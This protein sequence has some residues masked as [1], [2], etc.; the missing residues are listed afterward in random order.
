MNINIKVEEMI[1]LEHLENLRKGSYDWVSKEEYRIECEIAMP[2]LLAELKT[3]RDE[4][5]RFRNGYDN[6]LAAFRKA[7]ALPLECLS[8]EDLE[9]WT[10]TISGILLAL[11]PYMETGRPL[12]IME[13]LKEKIKDDHD[14]YLQTGRF[15]WKC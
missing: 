11:G 2:A 9:E 10:D 6:L 8:Q 7:P 13:A 14:W 15:A 5:A 4:N 3:L 1:D 12:T